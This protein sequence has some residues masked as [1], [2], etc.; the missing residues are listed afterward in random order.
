M[1]QIRQDKPFLIALLQA[2]DFYFELNELP[3]DIEYD[4]LSPIRIRQSGFAPRVYEEQ[5]YVLECI[6]AIAQPVPRTRMLWDKRKC[7]LRNVGIENRG[8]KSDPRQSRL[9]LRDI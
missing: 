6:T 4:A 7:T 3:P 1:Y 5:Q 9:P 2:S 8:G